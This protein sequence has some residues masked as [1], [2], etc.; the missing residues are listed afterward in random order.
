V[1]LRGFAAVAAVDGVEHQAEAQAKAIE[2]K[3]QADAL[4]AAIIAPR[5][6]EGVKFDIDF[7]V[8]DI[9][10]LYMAWRS[11]VELTPK[12]AVILAHLKAQKDRGE[13][14]GLAGILVTQKPR[15]S[16]K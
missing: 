3:A 15:I 1:T 2:E 8:T 6:A 10:A 4:A 5:Q 13:K 7:E 9:H 12:R 11:M 14:P 16:T